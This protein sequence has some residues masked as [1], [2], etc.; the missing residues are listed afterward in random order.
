MPIL[1][2]V[3]LAIMLV[4]I[5]VLLVVL[6]V[7]YVRNYRRYGSLLPPRRAKASPPVAAPTASRPDA[8][9]PP[10]QPQPAAALP[11][12][13][14]LEQDNHGGASTRIP[15]NHPVTVIGRDP[16]C[17]IRIDERF[18]T[19]SRRHAQIEREEDNYILSDISSSS[20]VYVDGT[21]IGRNRVR[22]GAV[23]QIGQEVQFTFRQ[24]PA[25][26]AP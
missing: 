7:V 16:A 14:Y 13:A 21:R 24:A 12:A 3:V 17:D 8:P 19:I 1:P 6:T 15:L 10:L 25:R 22:D 23:I 20:G 9:L 4:I 18:V 11:D 5:I 26:G 2:V